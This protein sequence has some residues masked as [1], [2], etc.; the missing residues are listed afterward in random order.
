LFGMK[1]SL[2]SASMTACVSLE[3]HTPNRRRI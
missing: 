1:T 3:K 2:G